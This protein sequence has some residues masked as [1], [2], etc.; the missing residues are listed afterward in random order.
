MKK[1]KLFTIPRRIIAHGQHGDAKWMVYITTAGA[2]FAV[3]QQSFSLTQG[4]DDEVLDRSRFMADMFIAALRKLL[5]ASSFAAAKPKA[6][7]KVKKAL[8][9]AAAKTVKPAPKRRPTSK[10]RKAA[11]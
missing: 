9:R 7:R 2:H 11:R 10:R 4:D 8:K 6:A 3:D 5:P 1:N